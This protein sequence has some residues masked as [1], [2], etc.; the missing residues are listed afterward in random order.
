MVDWIQNWFEKPVC[1]NKYEQILCLC[2]SKWVHPYL[3]WQ[4]H[5]SGLNTVGSLHTLCGILVLTDKWQLL[6]FSS[7]LYFVIENNDMSR[8][9]FFRQ[10]TCRT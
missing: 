7:R 4:A 3:F 10:M 6:S 9:I 1:F 8:W 5:K 2:T